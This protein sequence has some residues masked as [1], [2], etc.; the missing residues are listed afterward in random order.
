MS[1]DKSPVVKDLGGESI[2]P[3]S[4]SGVGRVHKASIHLW[5]PLALP[6]PQLHHGGIQGQEARVTRFSSDQWATGFI[7]LQSD[8]PCK[9][10]R[11][12]I[13]QQREVKAD[14]P[15]ERAKPFKAEQ[16]NSATKRAMGTKSF[17]DNDPPEGFRKTVDSRSS[18]NPQT[19]DP[20]EEQRIDRA[21]D[22]DRMTGSIKAFGI[23]VHIPIAVAESGTD[24]RHPDS[25]RML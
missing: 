12:P 16:T 10:A 6:D 2:R 17:R 5:R 1:Q 9:R 3:Q 24:D 8:D 23:T 14:S 25:G 22:T 19:N 13:D 7:D 20:N 11:D 4:P 21:C 15:L 18:E